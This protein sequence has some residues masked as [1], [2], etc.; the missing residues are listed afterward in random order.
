[1]SRAVRVV[2]IVVVLALALAASAAFVQRVSLAEWLLLDRIAARGVSPAA[3]RVVEVGAR[4]IT[5]ADL[6]IGAPDAPDL[7]IA[8]IS[9]SWSLASL[10]EGRLDALH[11]TGVE[12]HGAMRDAHLSFGALD[13]LLPGDGSA[14]TA[15]VLPASEI[16]LEDARMQIETPK[17]VANGSLGGSLH[18]AGDGAID[19]HFALA[20]DGAG[21][22][23]HG[24]LTLSG[25]QGAPAFHAVLDA[26]AGLPISGHLEARGRVT[27]AD[28]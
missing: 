9:A 26:G 1:M 4:G 27:E 28:G 16:A 10:R 19:A 23:A 12:L 7:A 14:G 22:S 13:P 6:A 18:S 11:V 8:A 15:P 21:L 17:G 25:T 3:L 5:I 20:L 2:G 24:T